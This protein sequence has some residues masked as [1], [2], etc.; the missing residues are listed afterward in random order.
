M[1]K[2]RFKKVYVEITS[3]CNLNCSFCPPTLRPAA[4]MSVDQFRQVVGQIS[5]VTSHVYF[6]VKGEPL[7]HPQ[8]ADLLDI[9][10]ASALRVHIVTNGT[11]IRGQT[12]L[13]L[14]HPALHKINFSLH[15]F[16]KNQ[17]GDVA[18]YLDPIS[19]FARRAQEAQRV[20][21]ALRSWTGQETPKAGFRLGS[22][23]YMNYDAEF[24]WPS[25]DDPVSSTA[26]FCL[27]LRDQ[28]AILVDG[29]VVPCCLD[30][31][32]IM[33][34]GNLFAQPLPAILAS[35]R[36]TAFFQGFS[37]NRCEEPLCQRCRF[38]DRFGS[39]P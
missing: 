3:A 8:L 28:L 31:N 30:G 17:G 26:G 25:L 14:G 29:T 16:E 19:E 39:R 2:K 24:A 23:T 1:G 11:L 38:R 37:E 6:H 12:E 5:P 4:M 34:L 20:I 33:D 7:L 15:S 9:A 32:G 27:G 22:H 18:A 13:L 21:V 36:A 35:P 10:H